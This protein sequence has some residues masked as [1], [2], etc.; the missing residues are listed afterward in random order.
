MFGSARIVSDIALRFR[1]NLLLRG[2]RVQNINIGGGVGGE[3]PDNK[4]LEYALQHVHGIGRSKAHH[5][6]CELGVENKFVK[7]LSKRELYSIR[8]LLSKKS[9]LRETWQGWRA[10]SATEGSGTWITC[11]AADSGLIQMRAP[12]GAGK[13]LLERDRCGEGKLWFQS[14]AFQGAQFLLRPPD[15]ECTTPNFHINQPTLLVCLK[16]ETIISPHKI[17][18]SNYGYF[19]HSIG[20]YELPAVTEGK[21]EDSDGGSHGRNSGGGIGKMTLIMTISDNDNS[22]SKS[23]GDIN[24]M[25]TMTSDD[26]G[27]NNGNVSDRDN[28]NT[29]DDGVRCCGDGNDNGVR[30]KRDSCD[31]YNNTTNDDMNNDGGYA[32]GVGENN[33]EGGRMAMMVE[34]EVTVIQ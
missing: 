5:I 33:Y 16:V 13:L 18:R 25:V 14:A 21:L 24:V 17:S 28:N 9:A 27:M 29:S 12:G 1:Q 19:G 2:V 26:S 8:E 31:G 7:D 34:V 20:G 23:G 15:P 22:F 6:V 4:R 11:P 3:I 32:K 30:L 10:F